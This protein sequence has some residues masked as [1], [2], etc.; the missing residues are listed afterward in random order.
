M[1][2]NSNY[3][4]EPV[5]EDPDRYW[6]TPDLQMASTLVTA[7]FPVFNLQENDQDQTYFIFERTA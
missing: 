7:G 6:S 5:A 3:E 1:K 2:E 4:L